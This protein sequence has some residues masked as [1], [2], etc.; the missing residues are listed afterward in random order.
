MIPLVDLPANA[1]ILAINSGS[2][3]LKLGYLRKVHGD[4]QAVLASIAE[5]IGQGD[6]QV[7]LLDGNG[8]V[9]RVVDHVCVS[10]E[11]ALGQLVDFGREYLHEEPAIVGHRIVHGGPHLTRHQ[12]VTDGLLEQ[13]QNAVHFA[14]LHVPVALALIKQARLLFANAPVVACFDTAFH[15]E[16]PEVAHR[17][18]IA[19]E[20][21]EAG[22]RRYGFHG[23]SYESVVYRLRDRI[24]ER[25]IVAHLGNGS[26]LCALRWGKPVDTTMGFTPA[27]GIPMATRSGDLDPGVLLF[28]MTTRGMSADQ[29]EVMVNHQSGLAAISGGESDMKTLLLREEHG[30][31]AA[32]DAIEIYVRAIRK[33]IGAY[34][35]LLHGLD[36]VVFTGGIGEHSAEIRARI[37]RRMEFVHL[38]DD[39]DC[40]HV[41]VLPAEEERQIARIC[42]TIAHPS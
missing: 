30:D 38:T 42:R 28:L 6:G 21:D 13:L 22:V 29:L 32:Q 40:R 34:A 16:L 14:P 5:N 25:T 20:Y 4:E 36:L 8:I 19:S 39:P 1:L 11:E 9:L 12:L 18:P 33:T 41:L 7:R 23:L 37:C 10:H 2:S 27:G 17:L 35:A 24:P 31:R 26:S 3:S 15:C